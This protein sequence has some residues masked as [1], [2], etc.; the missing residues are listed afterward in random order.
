MAMTVPL[1]MWVMDH[2]LGRRDH[3]RMVAEKLP[4]LALA[5]AAGFLTL[6]TST[7][8]QTLLIEQVSCT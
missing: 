3:V 7:L 5:F 8:V 6:A 1:L 4:F 2:R